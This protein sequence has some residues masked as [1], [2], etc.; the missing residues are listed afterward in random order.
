MTI[1]S[2]MVVLALDGGQGGG[3]C[4]ADHLWFVVEDE[5]IGMMGKG[6]GPMA[7]CEPNLQFTRVLG[8]ELLN[9]N[10]CQQLAAS[11]TL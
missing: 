3:N 11:A 6:G 1:Y 10:C 7:L 9:G 8:Q 5:E 2:V 4:T